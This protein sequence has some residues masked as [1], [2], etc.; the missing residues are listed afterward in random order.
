MQ[1][2]M[3]YKQ[4]NSLLTNRLLVSKDMKQFRIV[5]SLYTFVSSEVERDS[6][7]NGRKKEVREE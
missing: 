2:Y 5:I 6:R 4:K 1:L 3:L 7:P